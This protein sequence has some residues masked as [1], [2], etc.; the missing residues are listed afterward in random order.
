MRSERYKKKGYTT[1]GRRLYKFSY[2]S[3]KD[4][5]PPESFQQ[6]NVMVD[7]C[8]KRIRVARV[9]LC[10]KKPGGK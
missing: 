8:F 2:S 5:K 7:L 6:R 4:R 10:S 3:G 9:L 1:Y